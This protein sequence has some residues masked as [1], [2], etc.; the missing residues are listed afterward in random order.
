MF[1]AASEP[2]DRGNGMRVIQRR[3]EQT[4]LRV[5]GDVAGFAVAAVAREV[6]ARRGVWADFFPIPCGQGIHAFDD[7]TVR[8]RRDVFLHALTAAQTALAAPLLHVDAALRA[9]IGSFGILDYLL[10]LASTSGEGI[11]RLVAASS[12]LTSGTQ[13]EL[14]SEGP[15]TVL[16]MSPMFETKSHFW[17]EETFAA[18]IRS[19]TNLAT[20]GKCKLESASFSTPDRG[21]RVAMQRKLGCPVHYASTKLANRAQLRWHRS[22]WD[23]RSSSAHPA[24]LPLLGVLPSGPPTLR[25]Q[26]RGILTRGLARNRVTAKSVA[27]DL[28]ISERTLHRR[29]DEEG[30]AFRTLASELRRNLSEQY[31]QGGA[32]HIEEIAQL[33]GY[34]TASAYRRARAAWHVTRKPRPVT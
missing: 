10:S 30:F 33:L 32:L 16:L 27:Q 14:R 13:L 20:E 12:M 1:C 8:V 4:P 28:G 2:K 31:E 23:S 15:W 3:S 6:A 25:D 26:V 21:V 5:G 22:A 17:D 24:M 11:T 34:S 7:P 29:L 9:P 18:L 19:R